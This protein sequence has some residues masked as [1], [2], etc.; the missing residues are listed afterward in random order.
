MKI[1]PPVVRVWSSVVSV[2]ATVAFGLTNIADEQRPIPLSRSLGKLHHPVTTTN[3]TA[4]HYFD[5]GL[6]LVFAFNHDAA[7]RSFNRAL[8]YD[9]NLAMAHW[10]VGLSLGPNINLPVSP[11]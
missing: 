8:H 3:E 4:Q 11:E 1:L 6:T 5:Q 10:G 9:P 2:T 7:A